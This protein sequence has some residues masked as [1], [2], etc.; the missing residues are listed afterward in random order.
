MWISTKLVP[1]TP[2]IC[3]SFKLKFIH[4]STT[5]IYIGLKLNYCFFRIYTPVDKLS[6]LKYQWIKTFFMII[7][8]SK[9]MYFILYQYS[10]PTLPAWVIKTEMKHTRFEIKVYLFFSGSRIFLTRERIQ[11]N[12]SDIMSWLCLIFHLPEKW[13]PPWPINKG[14]NKTRRNMTGGI[15]IDTLKPECY[16]RMLSSVHKKAFVINKMA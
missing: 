10:Y 2:F 15:N 12:G 4:Y 11:L 9:I 13:E 5:M 14:W 6:I 7:I 16:S 8:F 1:K 3:F